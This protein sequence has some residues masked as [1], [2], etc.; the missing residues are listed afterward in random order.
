MTIRKTVLAVLIAAVAT[1]MAAT[2]VHAQAQPAAQAP[3]RVFTQAE[4]DQMLAPVALYPDALLSQVLMASTYPIEVVEAARWTRANPGLTGDAAVRAVENE[5]WDPSVKS[6]VAF[7]QLLQ[8]MDEQLQWTQNLGDAFLAQEPA[9]MDTV[10]QLRRRA[11]AAGNLRTT[12][13][14][15]VV[16]QGPTIVVQSPPEVVYV[17]YYDPLV[18][19]GPWWHPAYRPV[20]WAPWPGYVRPRPGVSVSLW[21][22][23]PV[24][25]S[26]GFFF[27]DF[28]WGRRSVRVVRPDVHYYRPPTVVVNRTTVIN[29]N[30]T[31]DRR[32]WQHDPHHR[33]GTAYRSPE[34]RQRFADAKVER[35]DEQREARRDERGMDRRAAEKSAPAPR[36]VERAQVQERKAPEAKA[37][38]RPEQ[39]AQQ[40]QPQQQQREAQRDTQRDQRREAEQKARQERMAQREAQKGA[41]RDAPRPEARTEERKVAQPQPERPRAESQPRPQVE[42]RERPQAPVPQREAAR[43]Q[44]EQRP[45]AT[46]RQERPEARHEQRQERQEARQ[47]QRQERREARPE[48]RSERGGGERGGKGG[49]KS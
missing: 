7:P 49:D 13:Q 36:V 35:R 19:Y 42:A 4:L 8:R 37:E 44:P 33:R 2:G 26:A 43:P 22:G 45:Q 48:P 11:Q 21:F 24:G 6:L 20:V 17:P 23:A 1:P 25:V 16:Q 47:E 14:V 5:D 29:R 9:V 12:E 27:G 15:R 31:V 34:V 41:Q 3:Q 18:I 32:E 46:V 30:V 40:P 28:D 10:Q 38:S 39:R